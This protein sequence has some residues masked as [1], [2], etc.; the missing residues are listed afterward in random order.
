MN[1]ISCGSLVALQQRLPRVHAHEK[2]DGTPVLPAERALGWWC[3]EEKQRYGAYNGLSALEPSQVNVLDAT[4]GWRWY[5]RQE[6]WRERWQQVFE[7]ARQHGTLP[8]IVG[9]QARPL[10]HGEVLLSVWCKNQRQR[11]AGTHSSNH[12]RPLTEWEAAKLE[13]IPFWRWDYWDDQ[14]EQRFQEVAAFV[15]ASGR[16]PRRGCSKAS[17]LQ[18]GERCLGLWC[19]TQRERKKGRGLRALLTEQ[20]VARL[21]GMPRW[22]W[23]VGGAKSGNSSKASFGS[24]ASQTEQLR[25]NMG[26]GHAAVWLRNPACS[27]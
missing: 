6:H 1:C 14:W 16:L 18:R 26:E 27:V 9:S 12:H 15:A 20:Q 10:L 22:Y 13:D 25:Q 5:R 11:W 8:R 2:R 24:S 21:E 4:P 3:R 17:P 19:E 23:E 7:F